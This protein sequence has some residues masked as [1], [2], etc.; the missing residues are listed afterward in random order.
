MTF[1]QTNKKQRFIYQEA[2]FLQFL[3]YFF[4]KTCITCVCYSTLVSLCCILH[5]ATVFNIKLGTV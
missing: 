5:A 3:D 1:K 2:I 4:Y